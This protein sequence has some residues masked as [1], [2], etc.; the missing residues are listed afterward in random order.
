[1]LKYYSLHSSIAQLAEHSTVNRRVTGS[2]PVGGALVKPQPFRTVGVLFFL[3]L[4]RSSEFGCLGFSRKKSGGTRI[5]LPIS[6]WL[7]YLL[8]NRQFQCTWVLV[9]PL[10]RWRRLMGIVLILSFIQRDEGIDQVKACLLYNT[11]SLQI[12]HEQL[13]NNEA[14]ILIG[15]LPISSSE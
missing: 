9:D 4:Q 2:S 11:I 3:T 7:G 8:D 5:S 15:S 10:A 13:M 6:S 12:S 14:H 1:V